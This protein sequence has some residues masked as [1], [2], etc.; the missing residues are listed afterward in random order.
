MFDHLQHPQWPPRRPE[1][2]GMIAISLFFTIAVTSFVANSL[3]VPRMATQHLE[4][5]QLL[6]QH[7][8]RGKSMQLP[9]VEIRRWNSTTRTLARKR[10]LKCECHIDTQVSGQPIRHHASQFQ[11]CK[12]VTEADK[13][14]R[15]GYFSGA[16][17]EMRWHCT[18]QFEALRSE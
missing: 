1:R 12:L 10:A 17:V 4:S 3:F 14:W 2:S 9:K 13:Q 7:D 6:Q 11:M 5:T 16:A 15:K 8:S 18:D